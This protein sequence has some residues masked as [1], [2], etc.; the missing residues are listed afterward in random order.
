M[1][2]M[3]FFELFRV[4]SY[5]PKTEHLHFI[6]TENK[7]VFKELNQIFAQFLSNIAINGDNIIEASGFNISSVPFVSVNFHEPHLFW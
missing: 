6:K 2:T 5:K 7:L 1:S 4:T 3:C